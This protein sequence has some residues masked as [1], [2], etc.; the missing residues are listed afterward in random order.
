MTKNIALIFL[1]IF[2]LNPIIYSQSFM[3]E[4]GDILFQDLDTRLCNAIEKVTQGYNGSKFS[5]VGIIFLDNNNKPVV[6]ET[7]SSVICITPL[8][9]FLARS[10][11]N[12]GKSKVVVGRLK[13]EF[14]KIIPQAFETS[15]KLIGKPF[16]IVFSLDNDAYYCSEL[17]YTAFKNPDTKKSIFPVNKMTFKDPATGKL[18]KIWENYFSRLGIPVPEGKPGVNPGAISRSKH[19]QIIR[20]Y[21]TPTGWRNER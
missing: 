6:Y 16:D 2:F 8:K 17:V 20:P 12:K 10:F 7:G 15:K 19:L 9:K 4:N 21:G 5:H 3:H 18:M 13:E 14:K 1:L 11:D